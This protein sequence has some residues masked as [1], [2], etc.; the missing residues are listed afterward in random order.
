M[1]VTEPRSEEPVPAIL[2]SGS[3]AM[4]LK[5]TPTS[6]KQNMV[7]PWKAANVHKDSS[8]ASATSACTPEMAMKPRS[9]A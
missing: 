3:M 7:A 9:A 5:L 6:P 4:A 8:P 2:P 1:V